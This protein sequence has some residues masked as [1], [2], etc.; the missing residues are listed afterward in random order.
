MA[1]GRLVF[2][3]AKMLRGMGAC[4]GVSVAVIACASATIAASVWQKS[5]RPHVMIHD[6]RPFCLGM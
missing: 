5:T 1:A 6:R 3:A 4:R 2:T